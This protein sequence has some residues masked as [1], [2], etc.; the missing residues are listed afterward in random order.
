MRVAV[1]HLQHAGMHDVAEHVAKQADEVERELHEQH[2]HDDGDA[3][4][5]VMRRLD[6][7]RHEIQRLREEVNGLKRGR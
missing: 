5:E 1:E 2:R 6:E 3:V 7:I 4:H